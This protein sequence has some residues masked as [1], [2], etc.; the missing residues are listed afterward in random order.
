M[1]SA[2]LSADQGKIPGNEFQKQW[3]EDGR[4]VDKRTVLLDILAL[5]CN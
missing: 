3:R 1:R 2:D 5:V 4:G